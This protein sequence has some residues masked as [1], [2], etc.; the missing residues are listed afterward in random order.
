MLHRHNWVVLVKFVFFGLICCRLQTVCFE[1][2][3]MQFNFL[4]PGI[5]FTSRTL[6]VAKPP[7]EPNE[8]KSQY[9]IFTHSP[10]CICLC[11]HTMLI[12]S[13]A[14]LPHFVHSWFIVVFI[15]IFEGELVGL[16]HRNK[17]WMERGW[18]KWICFL[19]QWVPES[20]QPN[21]KSTGHKRSDVFLPFEFDR[22]NENPLHSV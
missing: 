12:L 21:P 10:R 5:N 9:T 3:L 1:I 18:L 17:R 20:D 13:S 16:M 7:H 2:R 4:S 14:I 6:S 11:N 15:W 22:T 19:F 8:W